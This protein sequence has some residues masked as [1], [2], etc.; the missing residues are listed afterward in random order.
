MELNVHEMENQENKKNKN[1]NKKKSNNYCSVYG[2]N[3]F[4]LTNECISFHRL[5]DLNEPKISWKNSFGI[6]ELVNR[7][8][9]WA[10]K[11]KLSEEALTKKQLQVCSKHFTPN[12]YLPGFNRIR[13]RLRPFA[14][15]SV[16]L[17][18]SSVIL[19]SPK[20]RSSPKKRVYQDQIEDECHD[21]NLNISSSTSIQVD[22]DSLTS[23]QTNDITVANNIINQL[24]TTQDNGTQVSSGDLVT[25]LISLIDHKKK[26]I[27]M[28]GICSFNALNEIINLHKQYFPDKRTHRLNLKERIIMVFLKLKQGLSFA[29]LSIL[30]NDLTSETCRSTYILMIPQLAQIMQSLVYWLSKQEI[31]SN[32]PFCFDNFNNVRVVLD[33][34]EISVQRPKCLT[35]RI[36]CYSNYKSTF[37]LKF[38]VGI[39]PGGL[40]SFISKPYGG[41]SSD[42]AI[43]EQSN[44][45]E[46]MQPP[47]AIMVDKGFLIDDIC[48]K[49][50][51]SIIRPPFLK[52]QTQFNKDDALLSKNIAKARVHIERI[53]QRLKSF[54]IF[55]QTFPWAH[56]HLASDI[57][58]IVGG[59]CNISPPIF[60]LDKFNS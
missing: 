15:P 44:I 29:I 8:R 38:L 39:T 49:K 55:Q 20:K 22:D 50:N 33:C 40:I 35:C 51:I 13:Q 5:P 18:K 6:E 11:L 46:N 60:S 47:D 28:T 27:T 54:K 24:K 23:N 58:A 57:M 56:V 42:K 10:V 17:P 19:P 21:E 14:V 31:L 59:L 34:T 3:S 43:F 7:R 32:L 1:K 53:N 30:F 48:K 26:L 37:T 2:C 52:N 36:K 41:R 12:D 4:Y 25:P 45:I 9:I 16:N